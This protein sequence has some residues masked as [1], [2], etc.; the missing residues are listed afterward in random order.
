M[1]LLSVSRVPCV[2]FSSRPRSNNGHFYRSKQIVRCSA[3]PNDGMKLTDEIASNLGRVCAPFAA[4]VFLLV[5][6]M[7]NRMPMVLARRL[8]E[9][10]PTR[11][12]INH[13]GKHLCTPTVHSI[14]SCTK[15]RDA[16]L[17]QKVQNEGFGEFQVRTSAQEEAYW[18]LG[19][20]V[21]IL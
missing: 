10:R 18:L 16:V 4:A 5:R 19:F 15:G 2:P 13:H 3:Q 11:S 8:S 14:R 7:E 12:R 21:V 1:D 17:D 9:F 20:R 6:D